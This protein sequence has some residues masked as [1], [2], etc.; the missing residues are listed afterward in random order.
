MQKDF[1]TIK[2]IQIMIIR[3][4]LLFIITLA[5]KFQPLIRRFQGL[6][7]IYLA[8]DSSSYRPRGM[9]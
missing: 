7:D 1:Q 4:F 3:L 9:E 2:K 8:E 6:N 5:M